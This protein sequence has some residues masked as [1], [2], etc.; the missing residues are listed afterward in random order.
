MTET[1]ICDNCGIE[2]PITKFGVGGHGRGRRKV[3]YSCRGR[4]YMENQIAKALAESNARIS[5]HSKGW[6][7]A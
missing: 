4:R 2:K 7:Y 5:R 3:C 1:R 6:G